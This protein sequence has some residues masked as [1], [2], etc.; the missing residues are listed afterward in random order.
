MVVG[1]F[2]NSPYLVK[3][4]SN[5][6]SL[7][8]KHI[9]MSRKSR[10]TYGIASSNAFQMGDPSDYLFI[11]DDGRALFGGSKLLKKASG[12]WLLATHISHTSIRIPM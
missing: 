9:M 6:F 2:S 10:K 7:S 12:L 11:D 3:M 1:G 5:A 4:I 8:V